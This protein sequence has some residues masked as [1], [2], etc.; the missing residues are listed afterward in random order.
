MADAFGPYT[1]YEQLG[2]GGMAIVHRAEIVADGRTHVVALK[3]LLPE[4]ARDSSFVRRFID[5]ARLGQRIRHVNI[6]QTHEVGCIDGTHFI[7]LEYVHGPT[8]Q[9][10]LHHAMS[11]RAM[12]V[13]VALHIITQITRAL[14]YAHGL[15]DDNDR[16]IGLIHRDIAPSNII[17]ADTGTAKLI[18]FGVAK[19]SVGHVRTQAGSIIGKLGYVAPE[20]L[21]GKLDARVDLYSL[22]VVAHELL[23]AR[24]LFDVDDIRTAEQLRAREIEPPSRFN[25]SVPEELDAIIMAALQRDPDARWQTAYAMYTALVS[26]AHEAGLQVRDADVANW[27]TRELEVMP[28]QEPAAATPTAEIEIEIEMDL[29]EAFARVRAPTAA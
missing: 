28:R 6:A 23:T 10:L 17:I 7:A 20:Y 3:R 16:P 21:R 15:R 24:K 9:R 19:T 11:T 8:L 22:G 5:E 12:P 14:A 18:D 26:F 13:Y 29:E 4:L 27:V 1:V 25:D 2:V